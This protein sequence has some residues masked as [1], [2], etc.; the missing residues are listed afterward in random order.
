MSSLLRLGGPLAVLMSIA[1]GPPGLGPAETEEGE[2]SAENES[3]ESTTTDTTSSTDTDPG[4]TFVPE[5][6]DVLNY[7]ACDGFAQDCPEGEK[8]V[9]FGSTGGNW[10]ANKCVPILG[11][12]LPGAPCTYAGVV[13]STDDCGADSFC[14]DVHEVEGEPIGTCTEFCGGTADNP[15][16]PEGYACLIDSNGVFNLCIWMCDPIIQDCAPGLACYWANNDFNCILT[17]ENIPAG[18]P[19]GYINDCASGLGCFA[20][21][22]FPECAGSACC[23][24]FCDLGLGD[25]QCESV[26]GTSCVPFFAE[27]MAP[28]GYDH[29]GVCI[30]P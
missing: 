7:D 13:E 19:C 20:A 12:G 18:E 9:P 2:S 14:W 15:E 26:P 6:T 10:D 1:C 5:P 3:G 17:G 22:V 24:P 4:T 21:D 23:S 29:I 30:L 8:C 25:V 28:P 11:D 27:G 16:C